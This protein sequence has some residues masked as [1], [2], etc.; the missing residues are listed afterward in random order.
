MGNIC[1]HDD[2]KEMPIKKYCYKC[3]DYFKV[4]SGGYSQRRSCR[5]HNFENGT[6]VDC[7]SDISKAHKGCYHVRSKSI[8]DFFQ[9]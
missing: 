7:R 1:I 3:G 5:F 2:S 9:L 8:W 6:C 4:D